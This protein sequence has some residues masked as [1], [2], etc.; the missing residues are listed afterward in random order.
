MKSPIAL[1]ATTTCGDVCT[2]TSGLGAAGRNDIRTSW[3]SARSLLPSNVVHDCAASC[4][5][6]ATQK[7]RSL[8]S[9]FSLTKQGDDEPEEGEGKNASHGVRD[10]AVAM[11]GTPVHL[12][13]TQPMYQRANEERNDAQCEGFRTGAHCC[14][15]RTWAQGETRDSIGD[16]TT[17][18]SCNPWD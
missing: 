8:F 5:L 3:A 2:A 12:V 18:S 13:D 6:A 9:R 16:P 17:Q 15:E 14:A 10:V 7:R 1:A 11:A 4:R